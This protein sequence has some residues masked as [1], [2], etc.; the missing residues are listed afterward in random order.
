MRPEWID[1]NGHMTDS[2]YLQVFG[3][4]TDALFRY[5]GIDEAYR[6]S[7]RAL[8]T[9]ES[10]V[11]HKAEARS[12]ERLYVTSRL[13]EVDDKRV[14]LFHSLYRTRDDA[15]VATV[16]KLYLHVSTEAGRVVPMEAAVRERLSAIQA[17]TR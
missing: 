9:A 1:Y 6:R 10:H 2:R 3:D 4:A 17:A 11:V 12:Q 5:A 7:G 15:L 16:E 8:Y 14:R 13:L